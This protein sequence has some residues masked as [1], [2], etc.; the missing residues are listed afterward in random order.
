M[1]TPA[2][3]TLRVMSVLLRG[4]TG[5][6]Q[7]GAC[8]EHGGAV[9]ARGR[10]DGAVGGAPRADDE[11]VAGVRHSC[12]AGAHV[13]HVLHVAVEQAVEDRGDG[14]AEAAHPVEDR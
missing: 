14:D 13:T 11:G 2:T 8:C 10:E 12:E 3:K 5:P 6:G 9:L 7:D 1:P 4:R